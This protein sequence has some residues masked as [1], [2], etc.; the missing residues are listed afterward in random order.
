MADKCTKCGYDL[1]PMDKVCDNCGAKVNSSVDEPVQNNGKRKVKDDSRNTSKSGIKILIIVCCALVAT[2]VIIGA[3]ILVIGM[4]RSKQQ[5]NYAKMR[6]DII[7]DTVFEN[8]SYE[9]L[10]S[11][12]LKVLNDAIDDARLNVLYPEGRTST[13][14]KY[15]LKTDL[16]LIVESYEDMID[17]TPNALSEMES[18]GHTQAKVFA[19]ILWNNSTTLYQAIK[20]GE[21][22]DDLSSFN[23]YREELENAVMP[24][25]DFRK[26]IIE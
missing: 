7:N 10:F 26:A 19:E 4:L 13:A 16:T 22:T 8:D 6:Q 15:D 11:K 24:Y 14:G 12:K 9:Y 18:K 5:T 23:N 25:S 21:I 20:N 2:S 3:V 1:F 17:I